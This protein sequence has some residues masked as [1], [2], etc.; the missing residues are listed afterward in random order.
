YFAVKSSE[1]LKDNGILSFI[2]SSYFLDSNGNKHRKILNDL[3]NFISAFRMPND[4]FKN[5]HADTL[6][7]IFF[8]KEFLIKNNKNL[9]KEKQNQIIFL[10]M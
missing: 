10:W 1:L 7:D 6:T 8:T 4:V 5:S 3:G 2:I 9:L